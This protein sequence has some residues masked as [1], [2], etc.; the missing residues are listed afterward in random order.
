[1]IYDAGGE[2]RF[3]VDTETGVVRTVGNEPF[4][5]GKEYEIGV[6]AQDVNVKT[7]QRSATHSLKILVGDRDP[8]FYETQY[9]A[10]VP[11]TAVAQHQSVVHT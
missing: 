8:Q 1:L 9:T 2:D 6:S 5:Q 3:T 11:E 10:S 7:L 4:H